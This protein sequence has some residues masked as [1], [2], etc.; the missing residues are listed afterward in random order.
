MI[1]SFLCDDYNIVIR[2]NK[3]HCFDFDDFP[4]DLENFIENG[5][6]IKHSDFYGNN[7]FIVTNDDI[8]CWGEIDYFPEE[9][10]P[11]EIR[12]IA[13]GRG[14]N[15]A[16]T[17]KNKIYQWGPESF[18]VPCFEEEEIE[19]VLCL[20]NENLYASCQIVYNDHKVKHHRSP[21]S[22]KS[23]CRY[24]DGFIVFHHRKHFQKYDTFIHTSD[25]VEYFTNIMSKRIVF[26]NHTN[27]MKLHNRRLSI[28]AFQNNSFRPVSSRILHINLGT[29]KYLVICKDGRVFSSEK[30]LDN[31]VH[32]VG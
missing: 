8:Y 25:D 17:K 31:L 20:E 11:S 27:V 32:I 21:S 7:V 5:G 14:R 16:V 19:H 6:V 9:L 15:I 30:N 1:H 22:I 2:D 23:L 10:I 13:C 4:E 28:F 3:V 18:D 29:N 26:S 12:T 24:S